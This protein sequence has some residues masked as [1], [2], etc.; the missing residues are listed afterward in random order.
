MSPR[1]TSVLLATALL[2]LLLIGPAPAT[3]A[4][5][6]VNVWLTTTDDARGVNVT[7]GLQQQTPIAFT[8][9][10]GSGG[11]TITVNENTTYQT[12][13]GGGASFTDTA[14]WLMNSSGALSQ[15]TRDDTM[16]RL[17]DPDTGIGLSFVRNPMGSSGLARFGYTYGDVPAGQTDPGLANFT[18][19][20]DLAD[21]VPLT[22]QAKQLNPALKLMGTPWTAPAW[23]KDNDNLAQGWLE[24]Q[25]YRAYAAY[26][27]PTVDDA[28]IRNDP[29]F[30]GIAWHGYGGDVAQQTTVHN[31]YPWPH[32]GGCGTC[33]GLIPVHNGDSRHGQVDYTVEYYDMGHLTK[34]V[35][36]G[37]VRIDSRN[38]AWRNPD[39]SKA[40][41]ACN[42]TGSTWPGTPTSPTGPITGIG[43]KCLDV[44]DRS[45]ADGAQLQL[46]DCGG[47]PNQ[48]RVVSAA[49]DVVNPAANKC[50]DATGQSS[51]D[52]TRPQIWTCTGGSNQKWTVPV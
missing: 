17:F 20:H 18:I 10:T 46:W 32:F 40:L 9:G 2:G 52:G 38:V 42:T 21:V 24:A 43:G 30:G 33:T 31:Q 45:T 3:A 6:T 28:S 27:A 5:T 11:Q 34:F 48:Q 1:R 13:E 14:A 7:R 26:G 39:G 19:A 37:A 4:G 51:A 22:K 23:M 16:R 25:Y 44:K 50:L 15:T 47:T 36:P 35:R 41:I 12:F 8:A 29:L 49:R